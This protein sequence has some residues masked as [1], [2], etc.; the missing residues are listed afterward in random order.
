MAEA[1]KTWG[2]KE[3]GGAQSHA[4]SS[5]SDS[6]GAVKNVEITAEQSLG[7]RQMSE[8]AWSAGSD[9]PDQRSCELQFAG[10]EFQNSSSGGKPNGSRAAVQR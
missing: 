3:S 1:R 5:R 2:I 10:G 8:M 7:K 4:N 9:C 6:L